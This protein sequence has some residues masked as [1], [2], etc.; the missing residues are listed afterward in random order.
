MKKNNP[1]YGDIIEKIKRE[2]VADDVAASDSAAFRSLKE[3]KR[4]AAV[5][6]LRA[7][8]GQGLQLVFAHNQIAML[9]NVKTK[10]VEIAEL[11]PGQERSSKKLKYCDH[12]ELCLIIE[13]VIAKEQL[14]VTQDI[15]KCVSLL[16]AADIPHHVYPE[17]GL[18][19][20]LHDKGTVIT[21]NHK[22]LNYSYHSTTDDESY[23]NEPKHF[24]SYDWREIPE[25]KRL[26]FYTA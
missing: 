8:A 13:D 14:R 22:D 24:K 26:Q 2:K 3:V 17:T 15:K 4:V 21:I 23:L 6:S 9:F 18:V 5:Y 12:D 1:L 7:I 11:A 16:K 19:M 25:V 10:T 20:L